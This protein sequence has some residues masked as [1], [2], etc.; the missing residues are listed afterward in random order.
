M[1]NDDKTKPRVRIR[2][3]PP[4]SGG[5]PAEA[6]A[7]NAENRP[8]EPDYEVGFGKPP[9]A[10]QFKKGQSGNPNGRPKGIRNYRPLVQQE[11]DAVRTIRRDGEE[12]QLPTRHILILR[13]FEKALAGDLKALR[14]VLAF[15]DDFLETAKDELLATDDEQIT[16]EGDRAI[17]NEMIRIASRRPSDETADDEPTRPSN[18]RRK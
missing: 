2:R 17:I 14:E 15:D 11:L 13:L 6:T 5:R 8:A 3:R 1:A 7:D 9:K 4:Q 10:T 18:G 12:L 16:S